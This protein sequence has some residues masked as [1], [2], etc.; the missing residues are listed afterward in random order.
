METDSEHKANNHLTGKKE[1]LSHH[2]D[3]FMCNNCEKSVISL[4]HNHFIDNM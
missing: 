3:Q 2:V 4:Y 1:K